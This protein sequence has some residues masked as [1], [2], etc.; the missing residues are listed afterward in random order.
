MGNPVSKFIDGRSIRPNTGRG[1]L[2]SL[3]PA[4]GASCAPFFCATGLHPLSDLLRTLLHAQIGSVQILDAYTSFRL[5]AAS[6]PRS[7]ITS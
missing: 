2:Y 5:V 1:F 7:I 6:L 3:H 4:G